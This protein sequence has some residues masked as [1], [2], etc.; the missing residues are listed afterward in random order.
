M[1]Q[2]MWDSRWWCGSCGHVTPL[3]MVCGLSIRER[4][5]GHSRGRHLLWVPRGRYPSWALPLVGS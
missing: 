2:S 1:G 4:P 3:V 5:P